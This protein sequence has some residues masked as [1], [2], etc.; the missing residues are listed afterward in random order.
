[1]SVKIVPDKL[2]N[3]SQVLFESYSLLHVLLD[4]YYWSQP[5]KLQK[6]NYPTLPK[7]VVASKA[8][9]EKCGLA[10]FDV[11][12]P[13]L[14]A[15]TN[16]A[17]N[18][19]DSSKR[20]L[21]G[22]SSI[23]TVKKKYIQNKFV[24]KTDEDRLSICEELIGA[25]GDL[26]IYMVIQFELNR[27]DGCEL[28]SVSELTG[29]LNITQDVLYGE[30]LSIMD[31]FS[32]YPYGYEPIS[33]YYADLLDTDAAFVAECADCGFPLTDDKCVE[34]L[35][36]VTGLV[37]VKKE[38]EEFKKRATFSDVDDVGTDTNVTAPKTVIS[39]LG[40]E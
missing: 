2:K 4:A 38:V 19:E 30:M 34:V 9:L 14:C 21:D 33:K 23:G 37:K 32:Q 1:M 26:A 36:G 15:M 27:A 31:K 7:Y 11:N 40:L 28:L 10:S 12:Y 3:A 25:I 20:L 8:G 17:E 16:N 6:A 22:L 29:R 39:L 18:S 24:I 13:A 35:S 5:F